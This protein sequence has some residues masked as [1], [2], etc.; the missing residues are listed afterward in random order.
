VRPPVSEAYSTCFRAR[1]EDSG[2]N[3]RWI[4]IGNTSK[5]DPRP[6]FVRSR[7]EWG[8]QEACVVF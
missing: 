5:A 7:L 3:F 1:N 6:A 8:G 4:L 2:Q